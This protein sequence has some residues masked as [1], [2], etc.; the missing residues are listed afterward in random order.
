MTGDATQFSSVK[1]RVGTFRKEKALRIKALRSFCWERWV[2]LWRMVEQ[3]P[4][5]IGSSLAWRMGEKNPRIEI[6]VKISLRDQ[7]TAW[8]QI[9]NK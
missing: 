1:E 9:S 7:E 2:L 8:R 4:R 3:I 5:R 6:P